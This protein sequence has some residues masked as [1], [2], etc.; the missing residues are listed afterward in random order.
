MGEVS[1]GIVNYILHNISHIQYTHT[2]I[3]TQ[4]CIVMLYGY[5]VFDMKQ[6]SLILTSI[7]ATI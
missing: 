4:M 1:D 3:H 6:N 2:H 7:L 5:K